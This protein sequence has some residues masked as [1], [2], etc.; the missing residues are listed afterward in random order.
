MTSDGKSPD[1]WNYK[2]WEFLVGQQPAKILNDFF[3]EM[4]GYLEEEELRKLPVVIVCSN[5]GL[6]LQIPAGAMVSMIEYIPPEYHLL[7]AIDHAVI[8]L[9]L[10]ARTR[11]SPYG[12]YPR[13]AQAATTILPEFAKL[14]LQV[15]EMFHDPDLVQRQLKILNVASIFQKK[16]AEAEAEEKYFHK[17]IDIAKDIQEIT[18]LLM[19]NAKDASIMQ[20]NHLHSQVDKWQ[21]HFSDSQWNELTVLVLGGPMPR[22]GEVTMQYFS[23]RTGKQPEHNEFFKCPVQIESEK[24]KSRRLIYAENI[25]DSEEAIKLLGK[26]LVAESIGVDIFQDKNRL[27]YDL[28]A[29]AGLTHLLENCCDKK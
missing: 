19:E 21:K 3:L 12:R 20:L 26:I 18:P 28:L 5:N 2:K 22:I 11:A 29:E 9:Y 1:E 17:V 8:S 14:E 27:K 16:L 24:K 13:E 15:K 4:H 25:K 7:K 23:H 6:E 10:W